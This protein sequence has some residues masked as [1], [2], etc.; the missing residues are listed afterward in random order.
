MRHGAKSRLDTK[1]KWPQQNSWGASIDTF[2]KRNLRNQLGTRTRSEQVNLISICAGDTMVLR[3]HFSQKFQREQQWTAAKPLLW[4]RCS[5]RPVENSKTEQPVSRTT[6]AAC[7]QRYTMVNP[8]MSLLT[9]LKNNEQ[10]T[11]VV[12]VVVG[13]IYSRGNRCL[14]T[15]PPAEETWRHD[16][17][18]ARSDERRHC[19]GGGHCGLSVMKFTLRSL[20]ETYTRDAFFSHITAT[21]NVSSG[22]S[23][24]DYCK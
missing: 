23:I 20:A 24:K 7:K 4:Q 19:H 11:T 5:L 2:V 15:K 6:Q 12:I 1:K 22:S 17:Q 14:N 18:R 21:L 3:P 13:R 9:Q 8:T 10:P 16:W